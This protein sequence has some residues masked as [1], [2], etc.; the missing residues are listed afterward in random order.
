[1]KKEALGLYNIDMKYVRDLAQADDKVM[2]TSPQINKE[3]KHRAI[4]SIW[5][6]TLLNIK[7]LI[8]SIDKCEKKYII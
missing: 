1:M 6:R 5:M 3:N 4:S 8:K 7:K 2:S